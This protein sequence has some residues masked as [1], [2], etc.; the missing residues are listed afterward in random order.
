M[1]QERKQC[2]NCKQDFT[3]EPDDIKM[4]ERLDL[5][6]PMACPV[7]IWKHLLAFWIFGKFRKGK[8][9][10]SGKTIFTN[11]PENATFPIY[12]RE[13]WISDKWDPMTYGQDYNPDKKFFDQLKELQG[14]VPHPHQIVGPNNTNCE[15][16]DDV[17]NSKN[18]YLC[19]SLLECE[20]CS[21]GYRIWG[22]KNSIDLVFSFR[23]DNSYDC[24]YCFDSYQLRHSFNSKNCIDSAFLY[25]CRNCQNC[26]MCWNLR[27]KQ[28][29]ILNQPYSKEEYFEKIK[30]FAVDSYKNLQKLK[31]EFSETVGKEAVHKIN[32]NVKVASSTG[33]FLE[34]CKGCQNC[35][36]LQKSEDSRNSFRGMIKDA[37]YAVGTFAAEKA[38]YSLDDWTVFGTAHT[39]YCSN[40]R[41]SYYLNYCDN[42]EYCFGCVGLKNKSYCIL[43]KQYAKEEY[44]VLVAKIK[45][46]MKKD[47]EWGKFFPLSLAY[48]GYNLSIAQCYFPETKES[49]GKQGGLWDEVADSAQEGISGDDLPDKIS[50]VPDDFSKQAIICPA[51]KWR[52]NIASQE[53]EFYRR[54]NIPLPHYHPDK[55]FLDNFKSLTVV[56]PKAGKCYFCSKEITHYYPPEWGYKKITCDD[57]YLKEVV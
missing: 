1:N 9:D 37:I 38:A 56:E 22:C 49:I 50:D 24:T 23:M 29:H 39:F 43:N 33:N 7:C 27:N 3:I 55:R 31:K 4:L 16:C 13:E 19:R 18:C 28:Y 53:L 44:E 32:F 34:E 15:W 5:K 52:F 57:C 12:D 11:L 20:N 51:T 48:N 6:E 17:G 25:D 14:K 26:F 8:S 35:F 40:C 47:G 2:Q 45:E 41:Y 46:Q 30:T 42:C 36:F 21:Y 54:F 10:F